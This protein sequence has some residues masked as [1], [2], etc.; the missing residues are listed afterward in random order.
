MGRSRVRNGVGPNV[1]MA[2]AA[3]APSSLQVGGVCPLRA[4]LARGSTFKNPHTNDFVG[5]RK[6]ATLPAGACAPLRRGRWVYEWEEKKTKEK[7][8]QQLER[9]NYFSVVG[10]L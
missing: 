7:K 8:T 3:R 1:C 5:I 4:P 2:A 10:V 6:V 9:C